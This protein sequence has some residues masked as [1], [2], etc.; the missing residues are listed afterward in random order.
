MDCTTAAIELNASRWEQWV[1]AM[2]RAERLRALM[3][4]A[5]PRRRRQPPAK[6]PAPARASL[7][8]MLIVSAAGL[9]LLG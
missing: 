8:W 6:A 3:A 7:V 5:K 4:T 9:W 2:L 1:G